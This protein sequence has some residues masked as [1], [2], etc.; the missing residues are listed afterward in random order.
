MEDKVKKQLIRY[1]LEEAFAGNFAPLEGHRGLRESIPMLRQLSEN[2]SDRAISFPFQFVADDWIVTVAR[3][4][5]TSTSPIFGFDE[6]QSHVTYDVLHFHQFDQEE[7]VLEYLQADIM[8]VMQQLGFDMAG[9]PSAAE[10]IYPVSSPERPAVEPDRA[11]EL[12]RTTLENIVHSEG[13]F[14]FLK[15]HPA[16]E[17]I[18]PDLEMRKAMSPDAEVTFPLMVSDG[19][20]VACRSFWKQ[21]FVGEMFG[22]QAN[23]KY[24][25]FETLSLDRIADGRIVE[26]REF[27]DIPSMMRQLGPPQASPK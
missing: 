23:G 20:W 14:D 19:E 4:S 24:I 10:A 11:I 18:I 22:T 9:A 7:I 27:P 8:S 15:D 3:R 17:A 13:N 6:G 5:Y 1:L 2:T 16:Y 12:V 26:H 25:E 21:S